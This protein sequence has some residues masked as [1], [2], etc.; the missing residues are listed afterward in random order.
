M[1]HYFKCKLCDKSINIKS[2]KK[3]LN[4]QYHKSLSRSI[5][6]RYIITNP[7]FLQIENI[8]KN[9][10]LDYN[11]NFDCYLTICKWKI[12]F[13]STVIDV[14]SNEWCCISDDYYFREFVLSK[15]RY[16]EKRGHKFSHISKMNIT[17]V[18]HP[19]NITYEHY[20]AQPKSILEWKLNAL[21]AKKPKLIGIFG[22]SSHPLIRENQHI[23][24]DDGEN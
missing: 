11:K 18:A 10:A 2:K 21:L 6:S 4:S 13:S 24:E 12:H 8:L 22:N 16:Y 1:S 7:D 3:H 20:L 23:N 19:R 5:I 9:F 17:F 15:Y 14:K